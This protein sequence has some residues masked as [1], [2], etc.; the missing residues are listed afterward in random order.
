LAASL[1][2][3]FVLVCVV[4][5]V[6]P[7]P[8]QSRWAQNASRARQLWLKREHERTVQDTERLVVLTRNLR[9][10]AAEQ[11]KK[12]KLAD[13]LERT[14]TLERKAKELWEVV[15]KLDESILSVR[16]VTLAGEIRDGA[17]DL[18]RILEKS[19]A[20]EKLQPLQLFSREIEA[21]A[22]AIHKRMRNP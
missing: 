7:A 1:V 4:P 3:F 17:R 10:E 21:R 16:V 2:S 8:A 15:G 11:E 12:I 22:D 6:K 18:R 9:H 20:R 5:R 13:M 19:P 14:R